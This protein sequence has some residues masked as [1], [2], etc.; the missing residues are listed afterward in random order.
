[1]VTT[2]PPPTGSILYHVTLLTVSLWWGVDLILL[3]S[4]TED[5]HIYIHTHTHTHYVAFG[6]HF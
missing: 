5:I 4:Y 6:P 2:S 1:M 3:P